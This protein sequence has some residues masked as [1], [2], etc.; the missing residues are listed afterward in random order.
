MPA[1]WPPRSLRARVC[2][3]TEVTERARPPGLPVAEL[4]ERAPARPAV[5][6]IGPT[7]PPRTPFGC[8]V[9]DTTSMWAGPLCGRL[10]HQAGATVIKVE[11]A[12]RPD[13]SRSG[14]TAFFDWMNTGK[15]CYSAEWDDPVALRSLLS[16][17]DV[18][19][20]SS[21]PRGARPARPRPGDAR[22]A[23][24]GCASPRTF[25]TARTWCT[26]QGEQ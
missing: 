7:G 26:D 23:R 21:R 2:T 11:S 20:E 14:T 10:L 18:V 1:R 25:S 6:R 24:S 9:V 15:Y 19:L 16:H 3:A 8:L 5:R 13:G 12:V 4:G 17:A 22:P